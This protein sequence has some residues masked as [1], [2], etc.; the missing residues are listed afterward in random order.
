MPT[1]YRHSVPFEPASIEPVAQDRVDG[2]HRYFG[3]AP[4]VNE[5]RRVR[6][7]RRFLQRD[8]TALIPFE[9]LGDQRRDRRIDCDD[10]LAVRPGDVAIPKRALGRPDALFGF[11]LHSLARFLG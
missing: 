11:L 4:R 1:L 5:P 6:L 10:L 8:V 9:Q 3:A 7:T 2:A